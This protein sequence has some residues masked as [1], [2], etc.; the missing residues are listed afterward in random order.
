[1]AG[2][3][4]TFLVLDFDD[5]LNLHMIYLS[6]MDMGNAAK[7]NSS[8]LYDKEKEIFL[9]NLHALKLL[10]HILQDNGITITG[11]S[12]RL[13]MGLETKDKEMLE[14][15]KQKLDSSQLAGVDSTKPPDPDLINYVNNN[16]DAVSEILFH[17]K[18]DGL[19]TTLT[20]D[21]KNEYYFRE[22]LKNVDDNSIQ[23]NTFKNL[24]T[25]ITLK[26][27]SDEKATYYKEHLK[28]DLPYDTTLTEKSA[29]GLSASALNNGKNALF[30]NIKKEFPNVE[31]DVILVD[32]SH[33]LC[34][35]ATAAGYR[36]IEVKPPVVVS[37]TTW[38]NASDFVFTYSVQILTQMLKPAQI[39]KSIESFKSS[40][41]IDDATKT[42]KKTMHEKLCGN[43]P[44]YSSF[45]KLRERLNDDKKQLMN[46]WKEISRRGGI[47][48]SHMPFTMRPDYVRTVDKA[49]KTLTKQNKNGSDSIVQ[50]I[51]KIDDSITKAE[52][53]K[54]ALLPFHKK[55][56][57]FRLTKLKELKTALEA[58]KEA[59][60]SNAP[61]P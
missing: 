15:L 8:C 56:I 11:G 49:L 60:K 29:K 2:Q 1:M 22:S 40:E 23:K 19:T 37:D 43:N 6:H 28:N 27:D 47:F 48:S 32:D 35:S 4:K 30:E 36:A 7:K 31:C 9:P 20:L 44:D 14:L 51:K 25:P 12:Q 17:K 10:F 50:V 61:T 26:F 55:A 54:K 5:A 33:A 59:L 24:L 45:Y 34:E 57:E 42:L 16:K 18:A 3:K 13:G 41:S 58:K 39:Y 52:K 53:R 21:N 38:E 46:V